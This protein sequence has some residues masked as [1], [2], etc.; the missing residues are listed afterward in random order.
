MKIL[1]FHFM[2]LGSLGGV[3]VVVATLAERFTACGHP[4]GIAE[5]TKGFKEVRRLPSGTPVWGVT[6]SS[7][8]TL[9]RPR[10]WASFARSTAQFMKV[11]WAFK[12]D[13]VHVHFPLSQCLPVV[14]ASYMPRS[15]RLVVTVHNSDIRIAPLE[16][17]AVRN[18]QDR[19]FRRADAV[20]AVNQALLDDAMNLFPSITR[21]GHVIVNGVGPQWFRALQPVSNGNDYLLFAGRLSHVKGA[22]LLLK[23]WGGIHKSFPRTELWLA[24]EG[25]ERSNLEKLA[26]NLGI[27]GSTKFIGRQSHEQLISLYGHARAVVLPSRREGLPLS[28]LEAG[29]AGAICVGSRTPGIPEIIQDGVTGYLV[30]TESVEELG[31]GMKKVLSLSPQALGQM[32]QASQTMI[33]DRFSE[34]QMVSQYL[35]LFESL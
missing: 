34:R 31:M 9:R 3:D 6:V 13:I 5:I 29:A 17:P 30:G 24:G 23:A 35:Q 16:N 12:P 21:K 20:T 15:W 7:N 33:R 25:D 32:R 27:T 28:L 10:S 2:E 4:T 26:G 19:L 18:W 14:G 11:I 8:P 1:Q 22:D